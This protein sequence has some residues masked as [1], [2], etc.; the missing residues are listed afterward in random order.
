MRLSRFA[1]TPTRALV[2]GLI[3]LGTAGVLTTV[4][5]VGVQADVFP[6][7]RPLPP[8]Y[9]DWTVIH[10]VSAL[11][12]VL[13]APWQL[14]SGLR[15]RRPGLHRANGRV[16]AGAAVILAVSGLAMAYLPERPL[17][18]RLF[19]TTLFLGFLVMLAQGVASAIRRDIDSHRAWMVRMIATGLT[20][21]TQ[22]LVFGVLA[23]SLGIDGP[24]R[25][26]ELFVSAAWIAWLI[27]LTAAEWWIRSQASRPARGALATA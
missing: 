6:K 24:Q 9:P 14:L 20:P 18:E 13:L 11:A 26:W 15:R 8:A 2:A 3:V 17:M 1:V 23:G 4:H 21:M 5:A 10:F 22:R 25:F 7:G 27:Q 16:T 19:M 12:F